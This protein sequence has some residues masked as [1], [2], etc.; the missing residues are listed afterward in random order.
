MKTLHKYKYSVVFSFHKDI[1]QYTKIWMNLEDVTFLEVSQ[2]QKDA[3]CVISLG[4]ST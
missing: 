4:R 2:L 1:L 3:H